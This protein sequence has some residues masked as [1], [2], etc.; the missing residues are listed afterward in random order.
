MRTHSVRGGFGTQLGA[1]ES[2]K[3]IPLV[4]SWFGSLLE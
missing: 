3:N 2:D 1:D 4:R